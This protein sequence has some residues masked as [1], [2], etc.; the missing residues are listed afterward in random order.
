M[1]RAA[2]I[3]LAR[4]RFWSRFYRFQPAL[5]IAEI[6]QR[7]VDLGD[8]VCRCDDERLKKSLVDFANEIAITSME[9][10]EP[11]DF[12][13]PA[14]IAE[15]KVRGANGLVKDGIVCIAPSCLC[16]AVRE[17]WQN[18]P[19]LAAYVRVPVAPLD[20]VYD[21]TKPDDE[22]E[23]KAMVAGVCRGEG[24]REVV[25]AFAKFYIVKMAMENPK[26]RDEIT[27]WLRYKEKLPWGLIDDIIR[28]LGRLR[29]R[30]SE[31]TV[32]RA[33]EQLRLTSR[34]ELL[35]IFGVEVE[36]EDVKV[37]CVRPEIVSAILG[38]LGLQPGGKYLSIICALSE[39][40]IERLNSLI[41]K[42]EKLREGV[43]DLLVSEGA[44]VDSLRRMIREYLGE[45]GVGGAVSEGGSGEIEAGEVGEE[46]ETREVEVPIE[47]GKS[48]VE[49]G[50]GVKRPGVKVE[51]KPEV[52]RSVLRGGAAINGLRARTI[53]D[54]KVNCIGPNADETDE[55]RFVRAAADLAMARGDAG[56]FFELL[57]AI[58]SRVFVAPLK[59]E[60]DYVYIR[61]TITRLLRAYG[62]KHVDKIVELYTPPKPNKLLDDALGGDFQGSIE[63]LK[64]V[65]EKAMG[66]ANGE[67]REALRNLHTILSNIAQLSPGALNEYAWVLIDAINA[68]RGRFSWGTHVV[69]LAT[70]LNLDPEE[71]CIR[72]AEAGRGRN[73]GETSY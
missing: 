9:E 47:T 65:V 24:K 30:V 73:K 18:D 27:D 54:I 41:S 46:T 71:V 48:E 31:K 66:S 26:F 39:R 64:L 59:E 4:S 3:E 21:L 58:A 38:K 57:D 40:E 37:Q 45:V 56:E 35:R 15:V 33:L 51:A 16:E 2:I 62:I 23:L 49:T 22:V 14:V 13:F 32:S 50:E 63:Y 8:V 43:K 44:N 53:V 10:G 19:E 34:S 17:V 6:G 11:G 36:G 20:K 42:D 28:Y 5:S 60:R 61:G 29:L 1:G 70:Q 55:C 25:E 67:S 7:L 52:G 72:L 69:G 12:T 68:I